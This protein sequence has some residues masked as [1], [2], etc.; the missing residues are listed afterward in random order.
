MAKLFKQCI[1]SQSPFRPEVFFDY[2]GERGSD[3]QYRFTVSA[4]PASQSVLVSVAESIARSIPLLAGMKE[5][6][7]FGLQLNW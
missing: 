4:I 3:Q 2:P 5:R 1:V 6:H 7:C